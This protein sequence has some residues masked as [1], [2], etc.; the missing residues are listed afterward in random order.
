MYSHLIES[1]SDS[2]R[3]F[4]VLIAREAVFKIYMFVCIILLQSS[5]LLD[6]PI[7]EPEMMYFILN[8]KMPKPLDLESLIG[9][10]VSLFERYP[11]E[12]LG[13]WRGISRW[14]VLKTARWQEEMVRQT[15]GDGVGFFGRH[16]REMEW[17]KVRGEALK[18]GRKWL[19]VY[20][21]E[22]AVGMAV[23]VGL[24]GVWVRMTPSGTG[25]AL[26]AFWEKHIKN[27]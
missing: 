12:R 13:A 14:S 24:V 6:T 21:R 1:Y 3:V 7:E 4:D 2:T 5:L 25:S 18:A 26:R 11:P 8:N 17:Q 20:R 15:V 19:W 23:V 16:V 22:V 27:Q 10:A 9:D